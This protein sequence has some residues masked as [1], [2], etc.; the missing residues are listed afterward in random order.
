[1]RATV[2]SSFTVSVC[3]SGQGAGTL[4]S[5]IGRFTSKVP[6]HSRQRYA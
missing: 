3:P 5:L 6:V 1:M 4:D 2:V